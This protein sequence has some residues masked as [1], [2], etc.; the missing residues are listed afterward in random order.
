MDV[1]KQMYIFNKTRLPLVTATREVAYLNFRSFM[2]TYVFL[3]T[4]INIYTQK[5]NCIQYITCEESDVE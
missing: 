5:Q 1:F 3:H 4:H 2:Y